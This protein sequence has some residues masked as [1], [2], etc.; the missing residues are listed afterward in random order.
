MGRFPLFFRAEGVTVGQLCSDGYRFKKTE[1]DH[2]YEAGR[3]QV[4]LESGSPAFRFVLQHDPVSFM[5][6]R[7]R[8]ARSRS[9]HRTC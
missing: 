1:A 3:L 7:S 5:H 4:S 9:D 6:S 8:I 2:V